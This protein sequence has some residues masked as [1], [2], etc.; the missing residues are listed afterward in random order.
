ML[1]EDSRPEQEGPEAV[2]RVNSM[3]QARK[4]L[5]QD[6]QHAQYHQQ[7]HSN[8][9]HEDQSPPGRLSTVEYQK[10]RDDGTIQV[11]PDKSI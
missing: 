11:R 5:E 9:K 1:P 7:K 6:L 10:P 8:G 2:E 4:T 3:H